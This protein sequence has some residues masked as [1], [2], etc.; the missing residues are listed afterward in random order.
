MTEQ[1]RRDEYAREQGQYPYPWVFSLLWTFS[2]D[3]T[4]V[5]IQGAV[6]AAK[7][8]YPRFPACAVFEI[9]Q[10]LQ[11]REIVALGDGVLY[12]SILP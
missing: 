7:Q 2:R 12:P 3:S 1:S 9:I 10:D 5:K 4:L 6:W 11:A 8:L